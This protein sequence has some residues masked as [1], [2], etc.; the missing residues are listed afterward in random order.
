MVLILRINSPSLKMNYGTE[1]A[2]FPIN[3]FNGNLSEL[4]PVRSRLRPPPR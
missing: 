1:M 2:N 4:R 3:A